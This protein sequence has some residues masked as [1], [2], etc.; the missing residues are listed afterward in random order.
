M[1]ALVSPPVST[2][3]LRRAP[4]TKFS[5][6]V[7]F[8]RGY[9]VQMWVAHHLWMSASHL[10]RNC[11]ELLNPMAP[12]TSRNNYLALVSSSC[13]HSQFIWHYNPSPCLLRN[14]ENAVT[15]LHFHS[16][17]SGSRFLV[18]YYLFSVPCY[19]DFLKRREKLKDYQ[20]VKGKYD[21]IRRKTIAKQHNYL[22]ISVNLST[23]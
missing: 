4:K 7:I 23:F 15:L 8:F 2:R 12:R 16:Q 6:S 20:D 5:S 18:P 17:T 10:L 22:S 11:L 21:Y 9:R 14:T 1:S 13:L 19:Q 3:Q